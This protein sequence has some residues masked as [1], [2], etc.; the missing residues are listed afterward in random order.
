MLQTNTVSVLFTAGCLLIASAFIFKVSAVPFHSWAPDVYEGSP[1]IITAFMS[2]VVKTAAFGAFLKFIIVC[3]QS[4]P[5]LW[6][7]VLSVV[8]ILTMILGNAVALYQTNLKRMLA[9]SGIANAGYVMIALATVQSITYQYILFYMAS[10]SIATLVAFIIYFVVK[11]QNNRVDIDGLRGLA[12]GNKVLAV[13][14]C[15][16][17]LSL[18]GIPPMAG[19]IGKYGIFANALAQGYTWLVLIAI[20]NSLIGVYYYFRVMASCFQSAE[21]ATVVRTSTLLNILL[22]LCAALTFVF[23]I[24]PELLFQ[25]L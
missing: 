13:T 1:T 22:L 25:Y 7:N 23:G 2:T 16:A 20:I 6:Y 9:Y 24:Y 3:S 21:N 11:K 18:A 17:M 8:A 15:F 12:A 19:F 5:E 4:N 14:L 10:Y